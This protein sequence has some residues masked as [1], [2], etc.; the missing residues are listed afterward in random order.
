VPD[1]PL[2]GVDDLETP[3]WAEGYSQ[4]VKASP[5]AIAAAAPRTAAYVAR[6]SW[7][8]SPRLTVLSV[9]LQLAAGVLTAFGLLATADVFTQLLQQG[10]TPERIVAAV[11]AILVVVVALS[12]RA[13]LDAAVAATQGALAP[14]VEQIAQ[15]AL[16]RAVIAVDLAAFD[17]AD[18]ADLIERGADHGPSRVRAAVNDTGDLIAA[19]VSA[20]AAV[21]T[22]GVLHPLLAP[23]VLLAAI[24]QAWASVRT[25]RLMFASFVRMNSR[26]RRQNVT[27]ALIMRRNPAAE[28][29]AFTTQEVLL[30][31]HRRIADGL[32]AE[33]V[34]LSRDRT[35]VRL[36]GRA[37]GGVGAGLAYALLALLL[38]QEVLP[39]ALAGTAAVAM[40]TAAQSASR[41]IYEAN[42][43]YES[44]FYIGLLRSGIRDAAGR[45][46]PS[47]GTPSPSGPE[48][49]RLVGA[50]FRYP[51]QDVPAVDGIDVTL[52]RG[53]TI[54]LVG[55]NGS[56]KSTLAKLI[57]GLYL[58]DEGRVEWDGVDTREL[59]ERAVHDQVAV[60]LQD[61]LRW[62][63][64]AA[65]NVR[66]GRI[67][68]PD[69]EGARLAEATARSGAGAV[70][71]ELPAG[72]S[73][74]LSR[75]FQGGRDL[76]G[77]QWQRIAVARGLYRDA[78]VVIADEPTAA[79]DARAEH[80]VFETLRGLAEA[81]P[82][83]AGRITVLVTHRLANVRHADQILVLEK[84]A[85]VERGRH[86]ELLAAGGVYHELFTLQARA[87]GGR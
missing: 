37:L 82:G 68:A 56:G 10:P 53:E 28:I 43:L 13:L 34:L 8:A 35:I 17:D 75:E 58:P 66:I 3:Q 39:L 16:H 29:R 48:T 33:A 50:T 30:S 84:G 52:R 57:T 23:A 15:D 1:T 26:Y 45:T 70:V 5:M 32:T 74:V 64:T 71:E 78:P 20:A 9:V 47:G 77:G 55:E 44:S 76:S 65:D 24:P 80:A 59:S 41:M 81:A 36:I 86:D 49:I 79:L 6:W 54:A 38:Y 25:A 7:R 46:R 11:P 61:P 51:G 42:G 62:P 83:S 67:G 22:A 60:V 2:I 40:R 85:L 73:T 14:R 18:F 19:I 63:M 21:V 27:G 87:Y 31:E 72:W 4:T 12:G 69:D